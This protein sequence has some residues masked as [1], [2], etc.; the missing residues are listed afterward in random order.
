MTPLDATARLR[1]ALLLR[2]AA[3]AGRPPVNGI[4]GVEV[5]NAG[6]GG[7]GAITVVAELVFPI[8]VGEVTPA[9]VAIG[10]G[11][12]RPTV[13]VTALVPDG[14]TMRIA[15]DRRGDFSDYT[16]AIGRH[17]APLPGWDRLLSSARFGF[18][19][20]CEQPFDCRAEPPPDAPPP[21][22]LSVDYTARD[23]EGFRR[24]MLDRYAGSVPGWRDRGPADPVAVP[25]EILAHVY[26]LLSYRQDAAA[27]EATLGTA[28]RRTSAKR[29][30]RL[31]DYR[32]HDGA[33]AR[34]F[35]F[36]EMRRPPAGAA[37]RVADVEVGT[38]FAT[39]VADLPVATA[40]P[41]AID[42]AQEAGAI[43]FEA[44]APARLTSAHNRIVL[45]DHGGAEAA[46]S[47]G[48]TEATLADPERAVSIAP[49][50]FMLIEEVLDPA[51]GD[52][53]PEPARRHVVRIE[54][55]AADEDPVGARDE[56]GEPTA[57]PTLRIRW[58]AADAL[59]FALPLARVTSRD[60]LEGIEAGAPDQPS[61]VARGNIVAV[62]HG[63]TRVF[64][65]LRAAQQPGKRHMTVRIPDGPVTQAAPHSEAAA[66]LLRPDLAQAR[67]QV[68]VA[69]DVGAGGSQAWRVVADLV[70]SG[71]DDQ[72]LVLDVDDGEPPVLRSG[73]G[74][75]GRLPVTDDA[76]TVTARIGTGAAGAVGAEVIGHL[77]AVPRIALTTTPGGEAQL[78][79]ARIDG[80]RGEV[81]DIAA[82]R[83]PLPASGGIA[84]ETVRDVRRKAPVAF[85]QPMRAVTPE[86]YA[87]FLRADPLVQDVRATLRW[88]G[89]WRVFLLLVDLVGGVPLDPATVEAFRERLEP[90]RLAGH[91][92]EFRTPTLVPVEVAMRICLAADAIASDVERRLTALFS[93]GRLADGTV[94]L[95][96]PDRLTFGE[97]I[98]LSRLISAAQ[99]VPGVVAVDVTA[100]GR[101]GVPGTEAMEAGTLQLGELEVPV[102]AND[103]NFPDRGSVR[104]AFEGGR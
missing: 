93:S 61:A 79:P 21:A 37:A 59:P 63:E 34:T 54:D 57:L 51:T 9:D 27:T 24:L 44:L 30:A 82:I 87:E 42:V 98:R 69:Q 89:S 48:A 29:H 77:L 64:P 25:I 5:D 13:A 80:L 81:R 49:G 72:D 94:G 39:R 14:G 99:A 100:F 90:V 67:P 50:E 84:P 103:P 20:A 58:A 76:F 19:D 70:G 43:L 11:V 40:D 92:L 15:V 31:I 17:G 88:T 104:F 35:V 74:T 16:L 45:H 23:F 78:A 4:I 62:E 60:A 7:G 95:F 8:A 52:R 56:A 85:R 6:G 102:L 73:D 97:P 91:V 18:R 83:N 65:A 68:V 1:R 86:D 66:H 41:N 2:R 3:A 96:H 75:A 46:L 28:R 71:P 10:G 55:V 12:R 22:P 32:M 47:R 26:D 36:V 33:S 53:S 38:L 101:T